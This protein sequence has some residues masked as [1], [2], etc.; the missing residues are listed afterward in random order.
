SGLI[1]LGDLGGLIA[2]LVGAAAHDRGRF[3][4]VLGK[5]GVSWHVG[6]VELYGQFELTFRLAR[7]RRG[8]ERVGRRR[9]LAILT[10]QP[11][12]IHRVVWTGTDGPL[13]ILHGIV[14]MFDSVI[15]ARK[16]VQ[17]RR[18]VAS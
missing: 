17:R 3:G 6:G 8:R 4:V 1:V 5:V 12:V 16:Q 9:F 15:G 2:G 14:P 10:S 18:V 13:A 11:Q 7:E